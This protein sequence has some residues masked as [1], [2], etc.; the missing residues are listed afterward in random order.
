MSG[1]RRCNKC[2]HGRIP[3]WMKVFSPKH[4]RD[5]GWVVL[6]CGICGTILSQRTMAKL[7]AR[8]VTRSV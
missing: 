5:K 8:M 4:I 7:D 6:C 1:A 3:F 2:S